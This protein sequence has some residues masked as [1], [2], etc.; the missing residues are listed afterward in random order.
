M[1][2]TALYRKF[3]PD[4]FDD[5]K[6]QDHIVTTLTNQIKANR[7]GHAYLFCGT[8]GTG[9]TTVAKIL[10]K[11]VNCEHPVNGSPC[12]ECAM[13]KAIQ[14]GTAM[15]VIEIDAASN[16]GVDNIREIREEV[17]Y[18]P[19]E[20]KY[21]VYI[22]DEVHMLST[23]A[24]NALL[25][26]L[27]EPPSYVIFILATT[28]AHKIPITILSR[29]QRY[30]FHR[31]SIDTIAAR[32]SELLT[33]EGVEAEEKAVRYVAKKGDGSMR[34]ALSLLDQCISFYLGQVL[35]YDK[36][37]DVLG[38]VDTEVFS[39]LLRKVLSG[40]VT[41]SIHVLEDLITGGRE[42][43]QFVS[44]F[45]WYM[46]NLLLVKTSENPEEA[47]DVSSENLKLLKE[48]S[49]MTDVETLMRYIRIFSDLSNQIRFASQ[50]RV[51]VEI[52]LIKL[53]RP[54]M[55][56][57]LD[58]V[59]DRLRV[60]EKQ[61]EERPVQQ[62][63]VRESEAGGAGEP[64]AA[65][66][67]T[68]TVQQQKPQKAAPEDLQKIVA[69]WRAIVGQT[70]GLFKQSL[71]RAVPKYNGETG[72]PILYVEFQDF[73]G[74]NYVDNPEAKKELQDIIVARTGKSVEIHML[75][76][77]KHQQTNLAQIT[78]DDALRENIHMDIVVEEDP[79]EES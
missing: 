30:D 52:A 13:C 55:E 34:D 57:N 28:E 38:A 39:R 59:L 14:A 62:V 5:V 73:L 70:T 69:G 46:R 36:V 76:A 58:S 64:G 25:K 3:R 2:Y 1:S 4:N 22:I 11:A 45:T 68:A 61:M 17:A 26:T 50:K 33:A 29:C 42:L 20:G 63:I 77:N 37:L 15:N 27:E 31:I 79:D 35:T 16:N 78:V 7:I 49:G 65:V 43:G 32:L 23:G 12:N 74:M 8:R 56:T 67:G 75:V 21:K 72:D 19:T 18:R 71:Q 40:D 44:D 54:A 47:I 41:G 9:K 60:L 51:L 53:C 66:T 24:F 6:G 48:E 10:A